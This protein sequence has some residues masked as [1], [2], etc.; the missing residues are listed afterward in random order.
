MTQQATQWTRETSWR[1]SS[2]LR[3]ETAK[4]FGLQH[5]DSP[6]ETCVVVI[7]HDCDLANDN[8]TAEPS[9]E[10]II[11][12]VVSKADNNLMHGKVAR[13][14]HIRG[15]KNGKETFIELAAVAK[16]LIQ[17]ADLAGHMPDDSFVV[18]GQ[19]LS[20]LRSW[21]A[22]RYRRS[23]FADEF[24]DRM[25]ATGLAEKLTSLGKQYGDLVTMVGLTVDGGTLTE[26]KKDDPYKLSVVFVHLPGDDAE[27]TADR[28]EELVKKFQDSATD[29]LKDGGQ[30][31]LKGCVAV[32][33]D[34]LRV[35]RQRLL[36]EWDLEY[37]SM[38][39]E[40]Q[41]QRA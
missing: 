22:A 35:S 18:D 40:K 41:A 37:L 6:D 32:S 24:N 9:V 33:E 11:G 13:R 25:K 31:I 23:V 3:A 38:R 7:T 21:L 29:C 4:Q 5:S 1:Q 17:K 8:L 39:D 34:D 15:C 20:I 30:L 2:A 12:K 14:L 27:V 28:M 36:S 16:A 19:N 10:V 26:R